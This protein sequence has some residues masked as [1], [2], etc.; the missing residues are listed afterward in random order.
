MAH[1][2]C[3]DPVA[4]FWSITLGGVVGKEQRN[5]LRMGYIR[6]VFPYSLLTTNKLGSVDG[7]ARFC[8]STGSTSEMNSGTPR[9]THTHTTQDPPTPKPKLPA[10]APSP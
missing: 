5:I 2:G 8:P 4:H 3:E 1:M 7:R 10:C 9:H 6:I